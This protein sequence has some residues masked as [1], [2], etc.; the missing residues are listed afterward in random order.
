MTDRA[1]DLNSTRNIAADRRDRILNG[2]LRQQVIRLAMPTL[3]QQFL[4]FC[5][6]MFDTWLSGRIDTAATTSIGVSADVGWL[7]GLL[8]STVG[9]GTTA[10]V[11]RHCGAREP[12]QANKVMN[13]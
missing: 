7:A 3:L 8:V 1:Q 11:A 2:N 10:M 12:E 4:T 9:I 13:V 5:V 6:G